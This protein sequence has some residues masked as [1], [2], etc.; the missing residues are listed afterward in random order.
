MV[1][2]AKFRP[3]DQLCDAPVYPSAQK[4][5]HLL[6]KTMPS[7][8]SVSTLVAVR[9]GH[10]MASQLGELPSSMPLAMQVII[11]ALPV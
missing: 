10:A 6:P 2:W 9:I 3:Q 1:S 4:A 5:V 8:P 11:V 7:Q